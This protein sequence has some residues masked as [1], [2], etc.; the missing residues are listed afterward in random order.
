MTSDSHPHHRWGLQKGPPSRFPRDV[1][2][3][4]TPEP[5][6]SARPQPGVPEVDEQTSI[7]ARIEP[8][9]HAVV[10]DTLERIAALQAEAVREARDQ[11][12]A[13]A[14]AEV[15]A[16]RRNEREAFEKLHA[17]LSRHSAGLDQIARSVSGLVVSL[18]KELEQIDSAVAELTGASPTVDSE[19]PVG[20]PAASAQPTADT[21]P[22]PRNGLVGRLLR[23]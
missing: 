10:D 4:T 6:R 20:G 13:E 1:P 9:L 15:Q 5:V 7:A 12:Q 18:R 22:Q 17:G 19:A 8:Q 16:E 11:A 2:H 21:G 23:H 14:Q 3:P